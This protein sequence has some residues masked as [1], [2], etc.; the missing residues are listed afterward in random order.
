MHTFKKLSLSTILIF[1]MALTLLYAAFILK[2]NS[3]LPQL[4]VS[5]Q[6]LAFNFKNQFLLLFSTGQKRLI[7]DI[8]W[9]KTLLDSDHEHYHKKDLNS[10]MY[11]RFNSI[12]E[13]D[14]RFKMN[15]LFGGQ[16]LS[17]VKDDVLG[18]NEILKKGIRV[19]PNE[20][21]FLKMLGYNYTFELQDYKNGYKYYN[22][23]LKTG[24]APEFMKSLLSKI[25]YEVN[26]DLAEARNTLQDILKEVA[27]DS[28]TAKK[29][30][31]DINTITIELDLR[32]LNGGNRGCNETDPYG[33]RYRNFSGEFVAPEGFVPYQ[34][35]R[36]N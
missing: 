8:F 12:A 5:K 34:L 3:E 18:A 28:V 1:F 32:C 15:Y 14:P 2:R 13:L 36:K 31:H 23:L 27:P 20:A 11:M 21:E 26:P 25:Q 17:I 7:S 35:H 4:Q 16:Y 29:I 33:A 24:K 19:Y 30:R 22:M 10:W 9:I 6:D